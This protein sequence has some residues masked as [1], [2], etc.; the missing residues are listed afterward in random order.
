M[1]HPVPHD[2]SPVS[3]TRIDKYHPLNGRDFTLSL[4]ILVGYNYGKLWV[5]KKY[6]QTDGGH[7]YAQQSY[8]HWILC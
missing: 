7:Q 4:D 3:K 6:N 2:D 5:Y 8:C 1:P